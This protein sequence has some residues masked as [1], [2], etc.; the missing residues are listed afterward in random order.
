MADEPDSP[1]P[2]AIPT[3]PSEQTPPQFPPPQFPPQTPKPLTALRRAAYGALWLVL[4]GAIAAGLG[5]GA[6]RLVPGGWPIADTSA[7]QAQVQALA[8]DNAAFKVRLNTLAEAPVIDPALVDRIAALER[9]PV[10]PDTS[11]DLAA[12]LAALKA[13]V[14]ALASAPG[15]GADP[16]ALKALQDQV[17]ALSTAPAAAIDAA[18]TAAV[19]SAQD[20]LA[21][22]M[23]SAEASAAK[24]TADAALTRIA[25]ALDS[26]APYGSALAD[27][28]PVTVPAVLADH[29]ATGVPTVQA[30]R[31]A[32]PDAAREALDDARRADMGASWTDRVTAFLQTQTGARSLTPREG[33]DPDAILS[34]A[35]AQV[36]A[37]DLAA[38]LTELAALP[39]AAKASL[40]DWQ[41]QARLRLD[42]AAALADLAKAG[43]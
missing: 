37:G 15:G 23:A 27:L 33:N 13:Q 5:F 1:T 31:E 24:L 17:A 34:R 3:P 22:T 8:D 40:A 25:A 21:S 43:G 19:T 36:G 16:A 28:G 18:V 10:V 29:A 32:F 6:A 26:G 11:A 35:E 42:A 2:Q 7:L 20:Q 39:D 38:A 9:R 14:Q 12:G 30:L 41:A 4:G